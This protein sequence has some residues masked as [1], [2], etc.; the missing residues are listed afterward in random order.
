[1]SHPVIPAPVRFDGGGGEFVF[2]PG[3]TVAY[4]DAAVAP[5]VERFC[6]EVTRRT[7]LRL[8]P[9]ARQPGSER[10]VR[11]GRAWDG[12]RARRASRAGGCLG[13]GRPSRRTSRAGD[14]CRP[15]GRARGGTGRCRPRPDHAPAAGRDPVGRQR[16]GAH[17]ARGSS[18]RR[19]TP[20]AVCRWA[21]PARSS[22]WTRSGGYLEVPYA[23]PSVDPAQ[24]E[25]QGRVGLRLY[26]PMTVV[27]SFDWEPADALGPGRAGQVAGSRRRSGPRRFPTSTTYASCCCPAWPASP[28][29]RGATRGW[30]AGPTTATVSRGTAGC[31]RRTTSPGS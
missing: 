25:R 7:G 4:S 10:T 13:G 21:S 31:G 2:R 24:A 3:T 20:G 9:H 6:S 15:G 18:T 22:P 12:G 11:Q 16:R 8:A 28:T 1:M 14:R 27:E 5:I 26:S 17:R 23:E 19:D 30:A 29:G